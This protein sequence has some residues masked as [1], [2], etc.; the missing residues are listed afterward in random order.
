[1]VSDSKGKTLCIGDKVKV[2][3]K[4]ALP[5]E[6]GWGR[7]IP[8]RHDTQYQQM[9]H[10]GEIISV[11]TIKVK[12]KNWCEFDIGYFDNIIKIDD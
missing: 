4:L 8:L 11:T 2:T 3:K 9:E 10:V 12:L 7:N 1:M 5:S 6:D